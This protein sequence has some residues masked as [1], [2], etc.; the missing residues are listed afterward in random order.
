MWIS[1]S[2]TP[3][4]QSTKEKVIQ[5]DFYTTTNTHTTVSIVHTYK[6]IYIYI[7]NTPILMDQIIQKILLCARRLTKITV[8][9]FPHSHSR[10]L[11]C[12]L[13]SSVSETLLI[14]RAL[15]FPETKKSCCFGVGSVS[16]LTH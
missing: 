9:N 1:L 6:R 7:N 5:L 14:S 11:A 8:L 12:M 16:I 2:E 15:V 4:K 3:I 13:A 10:L